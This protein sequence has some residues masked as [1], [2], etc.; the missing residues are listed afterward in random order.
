MYSYLIDLKT[1]V[2]K[3][4]WIKVY[5]AL[6]LISIL[7]EVSVLIRGSRLYYETA[8]LIMFEVWRLWII[9][10]SVIRLSPLTIITSSWLATVTL[11]LNT[12]VRSIDNH[13]L[14]YTFYLF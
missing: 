4:K 14:I 1:Q 10:N 7:L 5:F 13:C 11:I 12:L 3:F 2:S 6:S 9:I 8:I